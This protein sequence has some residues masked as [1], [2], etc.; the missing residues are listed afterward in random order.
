MRAMRPI[1]ICPCPCC[2][3]AAAR[4]APTRMGVGRGGLRWKGG[5]RF[6]GTEA[7]DIIFEHG[8][9]RP[10]PM[11]QRRQ[12]SVARSAENDPLFGRGLIAVGGESLGASENQLNGP[13]DFARSHG[14]D[15]LVRPEVAL[16]AE[17]AAHE[18]LP[19]IDL[20]QGDAQRLRRAFPGDLNLVEDTLNSRQCKRGQDRVPDRSISSP[21]RAE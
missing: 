14:A 20:A 2:G 9:A 17:T 5:A 4:F 6:Q 12:T 13:T 1:S 21:S 11:L 15:Y 3:P 8:G 7:L 10:R 19:H 16:P 18:R